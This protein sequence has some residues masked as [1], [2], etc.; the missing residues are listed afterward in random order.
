M[1]RVINKWS[2]GRHRDRMGKSCV[3]LLIFP[4]LPYICQDSLWARV[5][6]WRTLATRPSHL[7]TL[8]A[9]TFPYPSIASVPTPPWSI[10]SPLG[11]HSS[12]L[13]SGS[14]THART[15][16]EPGSDAATREPGMLMKCDHS[17]RSHQ[18][19]SQLGS[20]CE[21]VSSI[22]SKNAPIWLKGTSLGTPAYA[23]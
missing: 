8:T 3:C 21:E 15:L 22:A 11:A 6:Y 17:R 12:W 20:R 9:V 14:D 10:Y 2:C 23:I 19:L 5:P 4:I 16:E 13:Q 7:S 18:N 1:C